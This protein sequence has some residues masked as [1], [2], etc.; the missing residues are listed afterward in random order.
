MRIVLTCKCTHTNTH[1]PQLLINNESVECSLIV[2][3]ELQNCCRAQKTDR[4]ITI[5]IIT[6]RYELLTRR[7][8]HDD[9]L[10]R[11]SPIDKQVIG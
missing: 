3:L 11:S 8:I 9:C 2:L 4:C 6:R 5:N 7:Q 1:R 10:C